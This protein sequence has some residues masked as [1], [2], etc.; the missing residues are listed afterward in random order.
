MTKDDLKTGM[1]VELK[2]GTKYMVLLDTPCGDVLIRDAAWSPFSRYD[3]NLNQDNLYD[4]LCGIA[5]VYKPNG[6]Y[7]MERKYWGEM[8]LI[9]ERQK[10]KKMTLAEIEAELGYPV[11]IVEEV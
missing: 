11:D 10:P 8:E 2:N 9:W 5:R 7:Q 1:V 6:E 3:H 4:P